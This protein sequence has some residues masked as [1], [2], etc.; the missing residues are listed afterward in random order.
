MRYFCDFLSF[1]IVAIQLIIM[2]YYT[3]YS[4]HEGLW[5]GYKFIFEAEEGRS[6]GLALL[7]PVKSQVLKFFVLI[8]F[9]FD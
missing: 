6:D 4:L 2:D 9:Q 7:F 8:S 3:N 1:C 5:N